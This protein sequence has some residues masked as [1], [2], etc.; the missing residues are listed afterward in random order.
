VISG[1]DV[2]SDAARVRCPALV[3]HRRDASVIPVELS[4]ELAAALPN[5]RLDVVD[6]SSASLYFER[7]ERM[8]A[9]IVDFVTG[10]GSPAAAPS[11][12]RPE[13]GT[14]SR[15]R[16]DRPDGLTA[17][18]M[19]VLR[20]VAAGETNAEIARRLGLSV[21]TVER[22]AVNLYRK[23]DARGRADATAYAVRRGI[24]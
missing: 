1:V 6:G 15:L 22:H 8:V 2:S 24:V 3:I 14:A 10:A 7:P 20:L 23:I 11:R 18:E 19:D 16:H 4:E 13:Q 5:G 12:A 9:E 17:R 21:H